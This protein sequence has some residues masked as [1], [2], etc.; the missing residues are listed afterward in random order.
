MEG[1][2]Q[3]LDRCGR[4]RP[5]AELRL[6]ARH[7]RARHGQRR[8]P[9]THGERAHHR[10]GGEVQHGAGPGEADAERGQHRP[11]RHGR[12]A[13]RRA[14]RVAHQHHQEHHR[15]RHRPVRS[16]AP[17]GWPE[18][19]RRLLRRSGEADRTA[20]G[21]G[22]GAREGVRPA[23]QWHRRREQLARRGG[24]HPARLEHGAGGHRGHAA[25]L[26]HRGRHDRRPAAV[27]AHAR[28]RAH[29]PD[30]GQGHPHLQR[31]GPPGHELRD[32]GRDR[33]RQV[34]RLP[35]L[36]GGVPRRCAPVHPPAGRDARPA[37]GRI[38][39]RRLQPVPDRLP[40][41]RVHRPGAGGERA[42][43]GQL[44]PACQ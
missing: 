17:R 22:A 27:H 39:V 20:H 26:R 23:D 37:R 1:H 41:A 14:R 3:A 4:G 13:R 11:A 19:Q 8:G 36:R 35:A 6:P 31:V 24:V 43:A 18:H 42:R 29:R 5:G 44:E 15:R 33:C 30:G 9:G 2:H 34:H 38:G 21:G 16:V 10:L 25:R 7:V 28:L 40:G 32:G 12:Q